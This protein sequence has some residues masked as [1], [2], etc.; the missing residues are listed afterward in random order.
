MVS[1]IQQQYEEDMIEDT[2]RFTIDESLLI[3]KILAPS[4]LA[5]RPKGP[6]RREGASS[7]AFGRPLVWIVRCVGSLA[8]IKLVLSRPRASRRDQSFR[9]VASAVASGF[10]CLASLRVAISWLA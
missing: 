6:S 3:M 9:R 8:I 7:A 10:F 4:L 1:N 2:N 5:S